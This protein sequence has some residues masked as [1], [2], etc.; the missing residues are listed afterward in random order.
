MGILKDKKQDKGKQ[1]D[2]KEKFV[3]TTVTKDKLKERRI[4]VYPYLL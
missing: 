2:G 4:P 1:T 3:L